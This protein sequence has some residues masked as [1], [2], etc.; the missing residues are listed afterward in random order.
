MNCLMLFGHPNPHW[1]ISPRVALVV[2]RLC[3][4]PICCSMDDDCTNPGRIELCRCGTSTL[5]S[6]S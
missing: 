4:L 3:A 2:F 5:D 6:E 1:K